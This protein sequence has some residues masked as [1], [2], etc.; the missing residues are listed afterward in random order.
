MKALE[1]VF[2]QEKAIV[3]AFS[4]IVKTSH[5]LREPLFEALLSG[6]T[7]RCSVPGWVSS[8]A[9][10]RSLDSELEM[11][12]ASGDTLVITRTLHAGSRYCQ[13]CR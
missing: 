7:A 6:T 8:V 9:R 3:G 11:E 2:N 1:G 13:F 10:W 12:A 4:V 5:N